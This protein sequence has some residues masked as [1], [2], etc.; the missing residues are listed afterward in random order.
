M[1]W[2][3]AEAKQ[4]LSEVIRAA[5]E[6]P[7]LIYSRERL[8]AA[9]VSAEAYEEFQASRENRRSLAEAFSEL[10]QICREED[11]SLEVG[12]RRDRGNVLADI[13]DDA[14]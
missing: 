8:V 12:A 4:K 6:A 13:L 9:V 11:Y 14:R 2:K 10:R 3:V 7:Q 1:R 5:R